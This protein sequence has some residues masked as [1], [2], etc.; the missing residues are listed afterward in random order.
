MHDK[1]KPKISNINKSL[2]DSRKYWLI[3]LLLVFMTVV[4]IFNIENYIHPKFEIISLILIALISIFSINYYYNKGNN[5]VFKLVFIILLLF[6]LICA[7]VIPIDSVSDEYEHLSRAEITSRGILF[8]EYL[9]GSFESI[10]SM[11]NFY[12]NANGKTI[13]EVN[14]DTAKINSSLAHVGSAFE[15]N[16]FYGY[17]FSTIGILLAKLLDLNVIWLLWLGR[18]FN[19]VM[20][21]G[22]ISLA[23][24]KSPIFKIQ[25]FAIACLPVGLFQAFS[26]SIDS[27]V[28]GLGILTMAY[29]FNMFVNKFSKKELIIFSILCL[30][31]G[32]CKLPYLALIFLIFV[33]P[34]DNFEEDKYYLYSILSIV[35]VAVIGLLWNHFIALP[36]LYHSWRANY[37]I[38]KNVN[39]SRQLS[40][41]FSHPTDFIIQIL[42]LLNS[43]PQIFGGF[44]NFYSIR[45]GGEYVASYFISFL[46]TLFVAFIS[47]YPTNVKI[48]LKERIG[49]FIIFLIIY[50][51]TFVVQLL[52]WNPVGQMTFNGV[53]TRYFLV[54]FS[55]LPLIFT[56]YINKFENKKLD[57][58][59]IVLILFFISSMVIS[60]VSK[61]Y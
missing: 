1:I 32:L 19:V 10:S 24:K 26:V 29:F 23:I 35:V 57:N 2:F 40:F 14:G 5:E 17:I 52:S 33:I 12:D 39:V 11:S 37:F 38:Q 50:V 41:I 21:A 59:T 7:F 61:F 54:L 46:L 55:L 56:K 15:Q 34:R 25:L 13:F 58:F 31:T 49:V 18:I 45:E 9:N 3:Y 8:P 20:Y 47:L 48:G 53:H 42:H 51:G 6:G 16:P 22:L 36:G 27:F 4:S 44:F 43:I 30:L 28:A 60:L